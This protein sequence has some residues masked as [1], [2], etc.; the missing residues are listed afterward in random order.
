MKKLPKNFALK[1]HVRKTKKNVE[2]AQEATSRSLNKHLIRRW[3][4]F[5]EVR[6]FVVGWLVLVAVLALGVLLQTSSLRAYYMEDV[7]A[8]GGKYI[9]GIV[10]KF[11]TLNPIFS[12][13]NADSAV[14]KLVFS[15]LLKYDSENNLVGDLATQWELDDNETIYK[16]MIRNDVYWHDGQQLTADDVVFTYKAIQHPDTT[17]PLANNWKG[18]EIQALDE[19]TV[20][21]SLPNRY[22]PFLHSLTNGIVPK[23]LL[24]STPYEQLRSNN[25]NFEPIGSG[26]FQFDRLFNSD[27][28]QQVNLSR[29]E[30][31][32]EKPTYLDEFEIVGYEDYPQMIGAFGSGEI[33]AAT[34]LRSYDINELSSYSF[35]KQ[36][37]FPLFSQVFIFLNNSDPILKDVSIRKAL[38]FATDKKS[39]FTSTGALYPLSDSPLLNDQLGYNEKLVQPSF[40]LEKANQ[41]LDEAGWVRGKDG[42]RVKDGKQLQINI[43]SQNSD[44]YPAILAEIQK[45]WLKA[46]V[47]ADLSLINDQEFTQTFISTHDY[48]ALAFGVTQGVDPDV[49]PY[50]HSSQAVTDGFNLSNYKSADGDIALEAGRTRSD[51]ALREVKYQAFL[52]AWMK[53]SPAISLYQPVYNYIVRSLVSGIEQRSVSSPVDRF[54]DV[55]KWYVTTTQVR[56]NL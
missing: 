7:A 3:S 34:A 1:R 47:L 5:K 56:K 17:S 12:I 51:P 46:G 4:K 53:D 41:L 38:V 45:S 33:T 2:Q 15:S 39:I 30:G 13:S 44:E 55:N 11:S 24:G 49:F 52:E 6:R 20:S 32:Y 10:G 22:S 54:N 26:P 18:V 36:L 43:V 28:R 48:Q 35:T 21:F 27:E 31:Y 19:Y 29:N 50:W 42:V 40:D 37:Y 23:H 16:V 14:T 8:N 9:E 25:Y